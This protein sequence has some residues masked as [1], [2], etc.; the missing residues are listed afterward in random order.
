MISIHDFIDRIT[1]LRNVVIELGLEPLPA[2]IHQDNQSTIMLVENGGALKA[3]EV[4]IIYT[5]TKFML[6][7]FF[8]KPLQGKQFYYF[9]KCLMQSNE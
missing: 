5:P 4:S 9:R 8:T 3:N 6:A 7:D 2:I 1:F